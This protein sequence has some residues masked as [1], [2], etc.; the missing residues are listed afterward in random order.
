MITLSITVVCTHCY[1]SCFYIRRTTFQVQ[2][3]SEHF[4]D[5][6]KDYVVPEHQDLLSAS[7]CSFV[8][9]LFPPLP[10]ESTKSSKFSSIGSRFKVLFLE[11]SCYNQLKYLHISHLIVTSMLQ[12]PYLEVRNVITDC[13]FKLSRCNYNS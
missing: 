12:F 9:G 1:T 13:I 7:K 11:L 3:Q 8:A 5:K 6:N 4:L 10:E 2:Y